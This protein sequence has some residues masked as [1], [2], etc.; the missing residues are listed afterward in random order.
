MRGRFGAA[1]AW[2][3]VRPRRLSGAVVRPLNFTVRGCCSGERGKVCWRLR[4]SQLRG[5]L[6][7]RGAMTDAEFV[8]LR[9]CVT[10]SILA[11]WH[12][13]AGPFA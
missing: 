9:R 11:R 4:S 3:S 10:A 2:N 1:G 6:R 12:R 8:G 13:C 5:S 7:C